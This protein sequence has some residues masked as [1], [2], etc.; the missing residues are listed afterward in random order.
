M[1]KKKS[2]KIQAKLYYTEITFIR[3]VVRTVARVIRDFLNSTRF[4]IL[5]FKSDSPGQPSKNDFNRKSVDK[6]SIVCQQWNIE[7][8]VVKNITLFS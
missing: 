4:L 6:I 2:S 8:G 5:F 1:D 3:K 7:V